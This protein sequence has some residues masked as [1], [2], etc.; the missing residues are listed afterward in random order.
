MQQHHNGPFEVKS[1][2]KKKK[3]NRLTE[4]HKA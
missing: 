2:K 4:L 1:Y 3:A